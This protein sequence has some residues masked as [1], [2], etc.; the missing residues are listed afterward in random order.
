MIEHMTTILFHR[1]FLS[2]PKNLNHSNNAPGCGAGENF[3]PHK[4]GFQFV[5][6]NQEDG[7]KKLIVRYPFSSPSMRIQFKDLINKFCKEYK[8]EKIPQSVTIGYYFIDSNL[9]FYCFRPAVNIFV[10]PFLRLETVSSRIFYDLENLNIEIMED[11]L[12]EKKQYRASA[13]IQAAP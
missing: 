4:K 11:Y 6:K 7:S 12:N 3:M 2:S 5:V 9:M 1:K 10:I 13:R 8:I